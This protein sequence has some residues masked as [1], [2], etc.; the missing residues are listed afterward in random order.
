MTLE[1][2]VPVDCELFPGTRN[3]DWLRK[4]WVPADSSILNFRVISGWRSSG[5]LRNPSLRFT[6]KSG[7]ESPGNPCSCNHLE[8]WGCLREPSGPYEYRNP[9]SGWFREPNPWPRIFVWL[10]DRRFRV[11]TEFRFT[12]DARSSGWFR[13]PGVPGYYSNLEFRVTSEFRSSVLIR[14][15]AVPVE[16]GNPEFRCLRNLESRVIPLNESG[17]PE[18][19][20]TPEHGVQCDCGNQ[21][22]EPG[23]PGDSGNTEFLVAI[24]P[25]LPGVSGNRILEPEV[26][27]GSGNPVPCSRSHPELRGVTRG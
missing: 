6:R 15:P 16:S 27:G 20:V 8:L 7:F 1:P 18:F 4:T 25:G 24:E 26:P 23:F 2:G 14:K 3:S 11:N 12:L 10:W 9:S 22:R 17:N 5:W 21:I 13:E 19:L